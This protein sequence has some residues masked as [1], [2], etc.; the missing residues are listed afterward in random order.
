MNLRR[1]FKVAL[2][3]PGEHRDIVSKVAGCLRDALREERVFY[4]KYHQVE[5]A[6]HNLDLKLQD[7][8]GEQS[9]L[10]VVF[11]CQ[12]YQEKD[13]CGLEWRAIRSLLKKKNRNEDV[14]YFRLD[15]GEVEGVLHI[16]GFI[17]IQGL[18]AQPIANMII[19]RWSAGR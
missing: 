1:R 6:V 7:I 2:S 17:N 19:Q 10:I 8:Y 16:D 5:L 13:W 11:L 9:D 3:F 15:D 12:K 14:L 18:D 4:D